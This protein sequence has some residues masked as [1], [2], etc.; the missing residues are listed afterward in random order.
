MI[1]TFFLFFII[2]YAFGYFRLSFIYKNRF[3]VSHYFIYIFILIA[4]TTL[5]TFLSS[6]SFVAGPPYFIFLIYTLI[7]KPYKA[8]I[9]N[10]RSCFNLFVSSNWIGFKVFCQYSPTSMTSFAR[11]LYLLANVILTFIATILGIV[12]VVYFYRKEKNRTK[13]YD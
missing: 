12:S 3:T 7:Q 8:K 5:L 9:E 4:S 2:P 11:S 1:C 13:G 6:I 10:Y